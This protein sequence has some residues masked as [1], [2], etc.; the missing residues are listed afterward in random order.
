[1]KELKVS[2]FLYI[3]ISDRNFN[4]FFQY[5]TATKRARIESTKSGNVVCTF[6][7]FVANA[8]E[9]RTA[10]KVS[11]K[12]AELKDG[13]Q[14]LN[15]GTK[16]MTVS[17]QDD[18]QLV[19]QRIFQ[20]GQEIMKRILRDQ[21]NTDANGDELS[22]TPC[23]AISQEHV[24]C[25]GKIFC[26]GQADRLDNKACIFIGYDEN[27]TRT[28]EL[29]FSKLRPSVQVFPG[30]ICIIGGNNPRGKTFYVTE[31][32][33]ERILQ[34][35]P[36]PSKPLLPQ[37]LHMLIASAPFS[38][39]EDL[40]FDFLEKL[41]VQC[42][43]TKPDVV[44]L[45]GAFLP[46]KWDLISDIAKEL[47][48]HFN[49]MLTGISERVGESTKVVIVASADDINGSCCYPSR[50]YKFR[51]HPNLFMAPD[52]SIIEVNGIT[53]GITSADITQQLADSEFCV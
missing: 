21:N 44:I 42:Q 23:D 17:V 2:I 11:I 52:P 31:L 41:L 25:L 40:R 45:T 36:P 24:R 49:D 39:K 33:S 18:G 43:T 28:V 27:K 6:G 35:C 19:T 13:T 15:E 1:M 46:A 4:C 12:M 51:Q 53:I 38:A 3:S 9:P 29:N 7:N 26:G 10:Q 37:P 16:Y 20:V 8:A 47:D 14:W 48:E 5:S 34:H 22:L 30:E 32:H 50:P